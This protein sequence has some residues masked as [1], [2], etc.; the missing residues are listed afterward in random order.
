M[1]AL[2]ALEEMGNV[3]EGSRRAQEML[4]QALAT[5]DVFAQV[6]GGLNRA[7]W[8]IAADDVDSARSLAADAKRV[9]RMPQYSAMD[10][11]ALRIEVYCDLYEDR[12]T[13]G[14]AKLTAAWP[15]LRRSYL[16]HNTLMRS[17]I[18]NLRGRVA[19][20]LA[21]AH[22]THRRSRLRTASS[23]AHR[24]QQ[25]GRPDS[26]GHAALIHAGVAYLRGDAA[27]AAELLADAVERYSDA[28]MAL[29]AAAAAHRLA[30]WEPGPDGARLRATVAPLAGHGIVDPERWLAVHTPGFARR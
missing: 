29:A 11:Y 7:Y 12:A 18:F 27:S 24:L 1:A 14:W 8:H 30:N 9:W 6:V 26:L 21:Q 10:F 20:A 28:Q 25:T 15:A 19:L 5:G 17:D 22:P 23:D 2:R 13:A 4:D 16:I 3:R